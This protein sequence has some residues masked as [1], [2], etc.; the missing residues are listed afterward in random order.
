MMSEAE[1]ETQA[2][3]ARAVDT[4]DEALRIALNRKRQGSKQVIRIM[5]PT[6]RTP[7]ARYLVRPYNGRGEVATR[8]FVKAFYKD[9]MD[10][11]EAVLLAQIGSGGG[12]YSGP[13]E[14]KGK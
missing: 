3:P 7:H 9:G 14:E 6:K 2:F 12:W 8:I 1:R 4:Y 10:R 13:R 5:K 11:Q